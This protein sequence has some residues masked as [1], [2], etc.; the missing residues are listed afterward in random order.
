MSNLS[1]KLPNGVIITA[2][3]SEADIKRLESLIEVDS[4]QLNNPR[5]LLDG[6]VKCGKCNKTMLAS[7]TNREQP[8]RLSYRCRSWQSC[9]NRWVNSTYLNNYII[10]MINEILDYD[11]LRIKTFTSD[12][13]KD[14][15][16]TITDKISGILVELDDIK[17]KIR[18]SLSSIPNDDYILISSI[19][20]SDL[21]IIKSS[22][23]NDLHRYK[24]Q[25]DELREYNVI[26]IT[27]FKESFIK[28]IS[29]RNITEIRP[30][31][32]KIIPSI[33]LN[34]N[35]IIINI[36]FSLFFKEHNT[37]NVIKSVIIKRQDVM[38]LNKNKSSLI[39]F[40]E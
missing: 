37:A 3:D 10:N 8:K 27:D 35:E 4:Y 26:D 14:N 16:D 15:I 38:K 18:T 13:V 34:D 39:K 7:I 6:L 30:L 24:A 32:T 40:R 21:A 28:A 19:G 31:L 17:R 36:D 1:R 25:I 9:G 33:I 11:D 12:I 29:T 23:E 2:F 5:E 22:L 20:I